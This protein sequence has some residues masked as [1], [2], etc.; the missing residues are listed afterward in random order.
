MTQWWLFP[1]SSPITI[2]KARDQSLGAI[3]SPGDRKGTSAS[4][5]WPC[6]SLV[7]AGLSSESEKGLCLSATIGCFWVILILSM[8][9]PVLEVLLDP[10][11]CPATSQGSSMPDTQS[12]I[13]VTGWSVLQP[14]SEAS[15]SSLKLESTELH[16]SQFPRTTADSFLFLDF[17]KNFF[18]DFFPLGILEMKGKSLLSWFSV[19]KPPVGS[20]VHFLELIKI[21]IG[22]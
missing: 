20:L 19:L 12:M 5:R 8:A 17:F 4:P 6:P 9:F 21:N 1:G 3:G 18:G 13:F 11:K 22:N 14:I 7:V 2:Y 16:S 15:R 10:L